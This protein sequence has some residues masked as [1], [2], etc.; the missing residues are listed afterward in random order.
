MRFD[1]L[2]DAP[3]DFVDRLRSFRFPPALRWP[4]AVLS[5]IVFTS[6]GAYGI[7]S[8]AIASARATEAQALARYESSK[9]AVARARLERAHIAELLVLDAR[10]RE[11]RDSG[12]TV[13]TRLADIANHVPPHAWLTSLS[14]TA[15][16]ISLSGKSTG[17]PALSA[18]IAS[19]LTS[20][21]VTAPTLVRAGKD[22]RDHSN[23]VLSFE[24]QVN[25]RAR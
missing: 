6:L 1:Y 21:T 11:I 24:V 8:L 3:P 15:S 10:L 25:D 20:K 19:L 23:G 17:L 14:R 4:L 7:F 12:S 22:E 16:G 18:T 2:H 5:T 13:S 9:A